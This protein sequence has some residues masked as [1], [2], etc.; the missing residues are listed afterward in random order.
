M[1]LLTFL[2]DF[3][4]PMPDSATLFL[5]ILDALKVREKIIRCVDRAQ[6]HV[7]VIAE[8]GFHQS[9][10]TLSQ[11]SVVYKDAGE[12]FADGSME[13]RRY[14]RTVHATGKPA[15]H[16]AISDL[17]A[18]SH[19]LGVEELTHT[20][21]ACTAADSVEE[22]AKDV[23][24]MWGMG[25]LGVKLHTVEPTIAMPDSGMRAGFGR[26]ERF[27]LFTQTSDLVAVTHPHT[28]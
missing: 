15:D 18:N 1:N 19:T 21:R 7:K 12:L 14:D 5:R 16:V 24:A 9:S 22:V 25:H 8:G 27:E 20:P 10:F 11:E 3:D 28:R 6:V 26:C 4:K 17:V 13:Q 23:Y 2:E